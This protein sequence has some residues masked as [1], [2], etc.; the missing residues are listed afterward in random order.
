VNAVATIPVNL[1]N[2]TYRILIGGG[3][4][5]DLGPLCA[6]LPLTRRAA[7]VTNP[8]V[9]RLYGRRAAT[10]L[11]RAGFVGAVVEVPG[12]ERSKSLRHASRL[13]AEFL[14]HRLDRRSLVIALGGG[15]IGD[16]AGFAAA[17][18]L[19]GVPLVQVPTTLLAQV[20]SSIGGKVAVNH[21]VG[22]NLIGAF[23]Q[24]VLVIADVRTL[25]SLPPRELRAGLAEVVK[26]GIIADRELFD[27]VDTHLDAILRLEEG[28][29]AFVVE[30]SCAIKARV[31]E[32]DEREEG[33]RAILNFGHTVGHALEA[34]TDYRR[35]LHGEAIAVGIVVAMTLSVMRGLCGEADLRRVRSLLRRI[36][37]PV[38][39]S[40]DAKKIMNAIGYDKKVRNNIIHFVLTEGIGHATVAPL[41]DAEEL[42]AA[43]T[44]IRG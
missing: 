23:H 16:L 11:Q 33:R 43:L 44:A 40:V 19:R 30:R 18:Y 6:E 7:I 15:V 4:L 41:P 5:D 29:L 9:N 31:V 35:L 38:S 21:P 26:H 39:S 42:R 12:G 22:K 3:L 17:T 25:Q 36:G 1:G 28:P 10:S 13:Y 34:A 24:P 37:L 27:Y 20:D 8:V 32:S 14:R 2:R